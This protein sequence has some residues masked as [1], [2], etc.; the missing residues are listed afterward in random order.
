MLEEEKLFESLSPWQQLAVAA[1]L[2]RRMYAN[3]ALFCELSEFADAK[4]FQLILALVWE[5]VSGLNDDV[6]FEKQQHKLDLITPNPDDY[7]MYGVWPALDAITGL[8]ILIG[9]C[10]HWD[11]EEINSLLKLS[12]STIDAY[13]TLTDEAALSPTHPLHLLS[14]SFIQQAAQQLLAD[15]A[16]HGR[17][18]AVRN[19]RLMAEGV[20]ESN[21]GLAI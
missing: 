13:I 6:D 2:V 11:R 10:K 9:A 8:S 1:A 19:L 4:R 21:I 16:A 14:Q 20:E 7:D 17:K 5:F 12:R 15:I 18:Q 3:F